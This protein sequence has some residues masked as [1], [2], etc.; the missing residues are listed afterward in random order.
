[1]G[2]ESYLEVGAEGALAED[3]RGPKKALRG[4]RECRG[5]RGWPERDSSPALRG[6]CW[7]AFRSIRVE[8]ESPESAC[9]AL[10]FSARFT[11]LRLV[12]IQDLATTCIP[13]GLVPEPGVR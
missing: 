5:R 2:M 8:C 11:R 1:M 3:E 10:E 12:R 4:T 7:S 9:F 13:T 6:A